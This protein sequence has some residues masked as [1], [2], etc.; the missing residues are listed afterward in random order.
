MKSQNEIK[1]S[2]ERVAEHLSANPER[3]CNTLVSTIR[4]VAGVGVRTDSD[5]C[6]LAFRN[7]K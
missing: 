1:A 7:R 2:F 4:I 6:Q 3:G 5:T